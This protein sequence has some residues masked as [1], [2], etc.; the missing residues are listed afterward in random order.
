MKKLTIIGIVILIILSC[1]AI[2]TNYTAKNTFWLNLYQQSTVMIALEDLSPHNNDGNKNDAVLTYNDGFFMDGSGEYLYI[3]NSDDFD[4]GSTGKS[5]V[6]YMTNNTGS[7]RRTILQRLTGSPFKG[8][9]GD[10]LAD[11]KV[12]SACHSAD[13][14]YQF[15]DSTN[16]VNDG[17]D[18]CIILGVNASDMK[19]WVDKTLSDS[20][21]TGGAGCSDID[22]DDPIKAGDSEGRESDYLGNIIT[23][24]EYNRTLNQTDV[25]Y[26][27]DN[28]PGYN[29]YDVVSYFELKLKDTYE[30]ANINNFTAQINNESVTLNISTTNGSIG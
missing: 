4:I 25:N 18:H 9:Y 26:L 16:T 19:V 28:L 13:S 6:I 22:N 8:W 5:Y 2:A 23:I 14:D 21:T 12:R 24:V 10:I 29:P 7:T 15:V 30:D 11:G 3:N 20:D 1:S 17:G 27:C